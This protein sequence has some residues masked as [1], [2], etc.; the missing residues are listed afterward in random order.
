MINVR[1]KLTRDLP[2]DVKH[3]CIIGKVFDAH[4]QHT[5]VD[6]HGKENITLERG[7]P[8]EFKGADG[9][10]CVAFSHEY[11]ILRKL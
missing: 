6:R 9:S 1:I 10:I 5:R 4:Y 8:L 3:G 7:S 11:K 2:I